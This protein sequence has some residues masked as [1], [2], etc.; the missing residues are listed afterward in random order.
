MEQP[1][2]S[3]IIP[4]YNVEKYLEETVDSVVN[5]TL[6]EIEIILI[7]DGSEDKSLKIAEEYLKKDK[8]IILINQKN[9]GVS[10]ARNTGLKISNGEYI[11]FMDS[12]DFI[13]NDTLEIC[14]KNCI[15]NKLDFLFF[16]AISFLDSDSEN[17]IK[18]KFYDYNREK[19]REK[20][21]YFGE[22][23]TEKLLKENLFKSSAC[24]NFID[25]KYLA[26]IE[27]KFYEGIIHEDELFTFIL[28]LYSERTMYLN[29]K[30]FHRRIR[31]NSIVTSKKSEKNIE[32]YLT[33]IKELEK[34]MNSEINKNKRVLLLKRIKHIIIALVTISIY[35]EADLRKYYLK[36]I[37][38]INKEY[39]NFGENIK[40]KCIVFFYLIIQHIKKL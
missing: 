19:I 40:L 23:I 20:K 3:V 4:V 35:L 10:F 11:Y 5:Q 39:L 13:D 17:N 18:I 15:N 25:S 7:N 31:H 1:K 29:K 32:G 21:I 26:K 37:K 27:L 6:K 33:V 9:Q 14:Y 30:F 36:E 22:N 2:V 34:K 28:F 8:R 16:D 38:K 12:D 24:L